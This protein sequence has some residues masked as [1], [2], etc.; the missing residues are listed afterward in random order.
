MRTVADGGTHFSAELLD[1]LVDNLHDGHAQA[2]AL[3]SE[4]ER[5]VLPLICRGLSNQEIAD[6]LFISKRTVDNHR[7]NILEKTGC[8]NTVGMVVWAIKNGLVRLE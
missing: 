2:E 5:E 4:R 8:R 7:A 1:S 3:L 6:Q